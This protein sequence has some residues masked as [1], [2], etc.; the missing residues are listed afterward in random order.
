MLLQPKVRVASKFDRQTDR[1]DYGSRRELF[2]HPVVKPAPSIA[3]GSGRPP[4]EWG[5]K[6]LEELEQLRKNMEPPKYVEQVK[7]E[8]DAARPPVPVIPLQIPANEFEESE[9]AQ[10]AANEAPAPPAKV[11]VCIEKGGL[12]YINVS[13]IACYQGLNEHGKNK[14]K[15]GKEL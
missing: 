8:G 11:C 7:A 5:R 1:R 15:I 10:P 9:D 6:E 13:A 12:F 2:E 3:H 4:S 14:I